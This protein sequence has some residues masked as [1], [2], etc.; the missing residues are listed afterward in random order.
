M[1]SVPSKLRGE[2]HGQKYPWNV[3]CHG[4]GGVEGGSPEGSVYDRYKRRKPYS[5]AWIF[6]VLVANLSHLPFCTVPYF[7]PSFSFF[8]SFLFFMLPHI[9]LMTVFPCLKKVD[10]LQSTYTTT[11]I[12][13][14]K[15]G[16]VSICFTHPRA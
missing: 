7:L 11:A 12:A 2:F 5:G 3:S 10:Q 16:N 8:P 6:V 9:K 15:C 4:H 14:V 13:S 1:C